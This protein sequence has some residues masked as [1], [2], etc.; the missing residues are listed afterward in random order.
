VLKQASEKHSTIE[1]F[2]GDA[3]YR[4]TAL[5][6]VE[7]V[8]GLKLHISQKIYEYK[9]T[10]NTNDII[11]PIEIVPSNIIVKEG[12]LE[13]APKWVF[14]EKKSTFAQTQTTPSYQN[15]DGDD[16]FFD[17]WDKKG[18]GFQEATIIS[19]YS[20]IVVYTRTGIPQYNTKCGSKKDL[21][22]T[23]YCYGNQIL[24]DHGNG[25][26]S[27]FAHLTNDILV[28]EGDKVEA[29]TALGYLGNSGNTYGQHLHV[30]F[31]K[32]IVADDVKKRLNK[33]QYA[34]GVDPFAPSKGTGK[35]K[36]SKYAVKF[37]FEN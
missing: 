32:N 18:N 30:G 35:A 28:S 29:G 5:E 13:P 10:V 31:Y 12:W 22:G 23:D 27:R 8:L 25:I 1:A 21:F 15:H 19:P 9:L 11:P 37:N 4:K 14:S 2:S 3:G 6:F 36:Q 20:G 34:G 24:I 7:N 17:D 33:G 16:Y 26:Y